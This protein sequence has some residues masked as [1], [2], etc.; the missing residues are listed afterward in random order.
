[1]SLLTIAITNAVLAVA[2]VAALAAVSR[3]P[4]LLDSEPSR[5]HVELEPVLLAA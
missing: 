4:F 5:T 3:L 2:V 1:M